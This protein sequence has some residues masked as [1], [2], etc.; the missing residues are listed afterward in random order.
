MLRDVEWRYADP[1]T[2]SEGVTLTL[3]QR[4]RSGYLG[5]SWRRTDGNF[6][7][8]GSQLS[9]GGGRREAGGGTWEDADGPVVMAEASNGG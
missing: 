2:E 1:A 8:C 5:V 7:V 4:S 6:E 9:A 3:S